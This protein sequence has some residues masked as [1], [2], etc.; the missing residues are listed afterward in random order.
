MTAASVGLADRSNVALLQRLRNCEDWMQ[1]L[2][3]SL[4]AGGGD[5]SAHG[6][7][8]RILDAT[9]R[10]ESW[11]K[12]QVPQRFVAFALC[13]RLAVGAVQLLCIDG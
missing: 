6:R 12:R 10:A 7:H 9:T 4:L 5:T 3:G 2:V 11:Q 1:R 8:V 13:I